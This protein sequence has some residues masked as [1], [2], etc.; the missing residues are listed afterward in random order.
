MTMLDDLAEVV[1][2]VSAVNGGSGDSLQAMNTMSACALFIRTHADDIQRNAED[3]ARVDWLGYTCRTSTCY[4]NGQHPWNMATYKL[5][6]LRGPTFR[7]A[8]DAAMRPAHGAKGGVS[9]G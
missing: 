1:R 9:E 2:R 8:I 6:D 7:A 5:R 4:M 3:A